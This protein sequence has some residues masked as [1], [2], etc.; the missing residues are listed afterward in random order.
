MSDLGTDVI[1]A[2]KEIREQGRWE[3]VKKVAKIGK[4]AF[5]IAVVAGVLWYALQFPGETRIIK[6]GE[7]AGQIAAWYYT[8]INQL[9]KRNPKIKNINNIQ[10]GQEIIVRNKGPRG[11]IQLVVDMY[12]F[13]YDRKEK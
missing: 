7:W 6:Q 3:T 4:Y 11:L 12:D 5:R 10:A 2:E 8:T 1:S 13:H 9:E